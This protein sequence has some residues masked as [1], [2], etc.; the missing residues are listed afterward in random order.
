M[1]R[2]NT[3]I[4][5]SIIMAAVL[6]TIISVGTADSI[7]VN[8]L[9]R[10]CMSIQDAK[11]IT[12]FGKYPNEFPEGYSLECIAIENPN[13]LS[14]LITN[15]PTESTKWMSESVNPSEGNI[16]LHQVNEGAII[17][18]DKMAKL[19]TAEERIRTTIDGINKANP[20]RNA[21]YYSINGMSAYGVESCEGC[22][23]QIAD[24]GNGEIITA[25]Y[26]TKSKLKIIGENGERYSFYGN[27]PL[28]DLVKLGNSLQ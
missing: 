21:Q 9:D 8:N 15:Q 14:V 24:F 2:K 17:S 6:A 23:T 20:S 26:D 7:S 10:T 16:F 3:T 1:N 5:G 22:G 4:F 18:E 13:E 19:G 12:Q 25:A 11:K 28:D 27:V